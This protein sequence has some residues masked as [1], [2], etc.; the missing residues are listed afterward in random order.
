MQKHAH[1]INKKSCFY[2]SVANDRKIYNTAQNLY[3]TADSQVLH[4]DEQHGTLASHSLQFGW[5]NVLATRSLRFKKN[6]A[7]TVSFQTSAMKTDKLVQ[8]LIHL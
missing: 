3:V 1:K 2:S 6:A 5:L 7:V 8:N 4:G